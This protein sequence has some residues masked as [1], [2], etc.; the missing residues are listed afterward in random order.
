[1]TKSVFASKLRNELLRRL[2]TD[3]GYVNSR[4]I[5]GAMVPGEDTRGFKEIFFVVDANMP[6]AER[7][8]L[9]RAIAEALRLGRSNLRQA[10]F[11]VLIWN[12]KALSIGT[13]CRY[14]GLE[15]AF[16]NIPAPVAVGQWNSLCDTLVAHKY[17]HAEQLVL[18]C[19]KSM[20]A[21]TDVAPCHFLRNAVLTYFFTDEDLDETIRKTRMSS[22]ALNANDDIP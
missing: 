14:L 17:H 18:M 4:R 1:M 9:I 5:E 19:D 15:G 8:R 16:E 11:T 3:G 12:G 10:R 22:F 6:N 21:N 13:K 7:L 20:F 2:P